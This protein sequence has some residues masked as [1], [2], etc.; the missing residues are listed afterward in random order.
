MVKLL[1]ALSGT[2]VVPEVVEVEEPVLTVSEVVPVS[3][4]MVADVSDSVEGLSASTEVGSKN[5]V[6]ATQNGNGIFN[7]FN[8]RS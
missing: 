7:R 6:N 8:F 5:S 3:F 1:T 4:K 2:V